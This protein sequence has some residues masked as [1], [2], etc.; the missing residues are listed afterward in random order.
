MI[1]TVAALLCGAVAVRL[2][3]QRKRYVVRWGDTHRLPL[4]QRMHLARVADDAR[5]FTKTNG[6]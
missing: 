3:T 4:Y 1:L 5:T 6:R 2:A